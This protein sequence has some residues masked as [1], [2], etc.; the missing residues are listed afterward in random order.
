M[1]IRFYL[2]RSCQEIIRISGG[3]VAIVFVFGE[4]YIDREAQSSCSIVRLLN[5][6]DHFRHGSVAASAIG[7]E[8]PKYLSLFSQ[9]NVPVAFGSRRTRVKTA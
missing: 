1:K 9:M 4:S 3:G 8:L 6:M 2:I 5:T 7:P